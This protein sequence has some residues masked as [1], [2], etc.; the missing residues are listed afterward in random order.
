[1]AGVEV[2]DEG[3]GEFDGAAGFVPCPAVAVPGEPGAALGDV[4]ELGGVGVGEEEGV[5]VVGE[6]V[7][8]GGAEG[9]R[10]GFVDGQSG[11]AVGGRYGGRG[12]ASGDGGEVAGPLGL[13]AVA[14]AAQLRGGGGGG[15]SE[16]RRGGE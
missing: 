3:A 10:L 2:A 13:G 4:A 6:G 16:G 7:G 9:D 11:G 5:A 15:R 12:R 14:A 1:D 8:P